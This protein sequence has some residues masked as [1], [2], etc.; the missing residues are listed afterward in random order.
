[1]VVG[2]YTGGARASAG[3][4]MAAKRTMGQAMPIITQFLTNQQTSQQLA[5]SAKKVDVAEVMRVMFELG[6]FPA[7]NDMV[8]DMN[9]QDQQRWQQMQPGA[10]Q[11]NQ[12]QGKSQLLQQEYDRKEQIANEENIARAARDV[13]RQEFEKNTEPEQET[14]EPG[15][16][17]GIGASGE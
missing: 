5:I 15:A 1:M 12:L 14:G 11:Q 8:I 17:V 16:Q 13:M 3:S 6:D 4:K 2:T 10:Q 7:Y 9:P